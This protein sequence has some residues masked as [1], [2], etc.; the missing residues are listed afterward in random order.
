MRSDI[1]IS[2]KKA[3]FYV[4]IIMAFDRN[5]LNNR[6]IKSAI[7][8]FVLIFVVNVYILSDIE[9]ITSIL[10]QL[11][12]SGLKHCFLSNENIHFLFTAFILSIIA[13][14]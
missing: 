4:G 9:L 7:S 13:L 2:A 12:S 8:L 1:C 10:F 11:N 6:L 14:S 3:N 5:T